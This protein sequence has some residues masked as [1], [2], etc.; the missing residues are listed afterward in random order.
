MSYKSDIFKDVLNEFETEEMRDYCIDLLEMRDEINYSIP[1]STSLKYHNATQCKPGGQILHELMVATIM[2]YLLGLDYLREK[3][4]NPKQRDCLRIAA[5][6][7]D[8]KKTNGTKFTVHEHPVLGAEFVEYAKTE[9]NIDGAYKTYIGNL[10]KSHSG[11]WID[12]KRSSVVLPKPS[13]D[14]E[15]LVHLCDYLSSRSNLD[16]IY[17]DEIKTMVDEAISPEEKPD[18]ETYVF[19]F[20]KFKGY[21]FNQVKETDKSYLVWMKEKSDL[22]QREPL[23]SLLEGI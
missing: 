21:T 23:K 9:H 10:I 16:M 14:D 7:H 19:K 17:S 3:F 1:S 22:G 5:V 13:R 2:N 4:A 11:Q 15:F 12:S 18:P 20:G 8:C 6:M